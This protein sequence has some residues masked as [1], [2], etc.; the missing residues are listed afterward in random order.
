[1]TAAP[2]DAAPPAKAPADGVANTTEGAD[3]TADAAAAAAAAEVELAASAE[4]EEY[5]LNLYGFA[6]FMYSR[7]LT[8]S[9]LED[10]PASFAVGNLNLYMGSE[11]GDNWRWLSEVRFMYL[12]NGSI[13]YGTAVSPNPGPRLDTTVDDY[14]DLGSSIRWGGISIER[15]YLEHTFLSWFTIRAGQFLTPYGIWNVD[16][17]SPVILGARRPYIIGQAL[18][19][20]RQTGI[21][22]YGSGLVGPVELGYHLTVSN[23]RGP[24]D[25]YQDLDKNKALGGRAWLRHHSDEVGTVTLGGSG[26]RGRYTNSD[27]AASFSSEGTLQLSETLTEQY[28]ELALAADLK[29]ERKGL[30]VQSEA[31]LSDRAYTDSVRPPA[32]PQ[33]GPPGQIADH[34]RAGFYVLAGYRF[35][36]LGIMPWAGIDYF[37]F[38]KKDVYPTVAA[39]PMGVTL[40]PTARVTLKA[41]YTHVTFPGEPTLGGPAKPLNLLDLQAAWSF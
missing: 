13:P 18:F 10:R 11:L 29:W 38:G 39:F 34:R 6:D 25:S 22:L 27:P 1:M 8:K 40:R 3:A 16:H 37:S 20:A 23:G 41:Q 19:P 15:A 2:A 28:E 12:P 31:V 32:L 33:P 35:D 4:V 7:S 5:K 30:M 21:E 36:F 17:G 14:A 9:S 24:V 26:Y